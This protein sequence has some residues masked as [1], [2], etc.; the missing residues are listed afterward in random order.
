MFS[1]IIKYEYTLTVILSYLRMLA[2][3]IDDSTCE[4]Y[5]INI[6]VDEYSRVQRILYNARLE[7]HDIQLTI[8]PDDCECSGEPCCGIISNFSTP[9]TSCE[10][11]LC[12]FHRFSHTSKDHVA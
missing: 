11:P 2:D 7:R 8:R 12:P 1:L 10:V 4:L 5:I 3:N 6:L 9:V